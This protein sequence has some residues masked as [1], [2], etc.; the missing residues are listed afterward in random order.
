MEITAVALSTARNTLRER[1]ALWSAAATRVGELDFADSLDLVAVVRARTSSEPNFSGITRLN[2]VAHGNYHV[3]GLGRD[4]IT[5]RSFSRYEQTL[6]GLT[7]LFTRDAIVHFQA[8]RV[9]NDYDLIKQFA[10]VW[11]ASVV[12]PT[13]M[14]NLVVRAQ[15]PWGEYVRC[16]PNGQCRVGV[17]RP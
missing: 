5:L 2:I 12:A 9:G 16:E 17:P 15:A 3:I 10:R 14:Y 13:T 6:S 1:W 4:N 8:C 11:R 7:P